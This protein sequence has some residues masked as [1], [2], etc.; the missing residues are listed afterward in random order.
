VLEVED[1]EDRPLDVDVV[2]GLEL[3]RR[4]DGESAPV[5]GISDVVA[6]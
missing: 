5:A 6:G 1:L 4:D 2:A 3:V